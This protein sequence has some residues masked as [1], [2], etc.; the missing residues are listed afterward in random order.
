MFLLSI[1]RNCV[2]S[3]RRAFLFLWVLGIGY[4]ILLMQP[5]DLPINILRLEEEFLHLLSLNINVRKASVSCICIKNNIFILVGW[6]RRFCLL[7][8]PPGLN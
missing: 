3:V 5:L 2:S 6:D 7:L 4:V 1:T 8:G